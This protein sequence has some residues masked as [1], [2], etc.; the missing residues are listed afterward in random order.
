LHQLGE[1]VCRGILTAPSKQ[2]QPAA[3]HTDIQTNIQVLEERLIEINEELDSLYRQVTNLK[4]EKLLPT[5][6]LKEA[7]SKLETKRDNFT[8]S[9]QMWQTIREVYPNYDR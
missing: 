2:S 5:G 8:L 4:K 9:V 6:G 3:N 7:I 1:N